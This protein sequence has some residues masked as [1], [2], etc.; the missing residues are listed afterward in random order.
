MT[1][2]V[3]PEKGV[4]R[5]DIAPGQIGW[6]LFDMAALPNFQFETSATV[7]PATPLGAAAMI[8]R[9]VSAGNFYLFRVDGT[10]AVTIELWKEGQSFTVLPQ[11]AFPVVNRAGQANRLTLVDDG[12]QLRFFV[13]QAL[14]LYRGRSPTGGRSCRLGRAFQRQ[15]LHNGRFRLGDNLRQEHSKRRNRHAWHCLPNKRHISMQA[16]LAAVACGDDEEAE[17]CALQLTAAD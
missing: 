3:L 15:R 14:T 8:G 12:N 6:T 11:T 1:A 4:Y 10:G 2:T 16:F 17:R 5:L 7:D 13:N 9:F